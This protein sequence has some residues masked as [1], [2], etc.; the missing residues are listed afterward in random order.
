[1]KKL[2]IAIIALAFVGT[3]SFA[4][5]VPATTP[6]P[7]KLTVVKKPIT[8]KTEAKVVPITKTTT[9]TTTVVKEAKVAKAPK[10]VAP[11]ITAA[12]LKKDGTPDKR[13]KNTATTTN[14]AGPLKKDG[15]PDKRFK[16]NK[17]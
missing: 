11:L 14:A 6:A 15:T 7:S 3:K 5:A 12:P 8:K 16:A 17:K 1:M 13:F 4:Q 10:V 9:P 2:F